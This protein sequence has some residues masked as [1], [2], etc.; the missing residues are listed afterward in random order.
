MPQ[1]AEFAFRQSGFLYVC[2]VGKAIDPDRH[3]EY[4]KRHIWLEYAPPHF[5]ATYNPSIVEFSWGQIAAFV[6][7][8]IFSAWVRAARACRRVG[9]Y[10]VGGGMGQNKL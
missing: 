4:V 1:I 6:Q 2:E 9:L 10:F 3:F 7:Q 5:G 8:R